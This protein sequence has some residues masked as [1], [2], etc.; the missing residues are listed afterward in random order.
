LALGCGLPSP[1]R[2]GVDNWKSINNHRAPISNHQSA[3][4][5]QQSPI[6]NHQSAITNQQSPINLK[7]AI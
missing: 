6:S 5:N 7:S 4:T 2:D 3:I 1:V